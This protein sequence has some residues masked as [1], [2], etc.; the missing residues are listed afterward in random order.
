MKKPVILDLRNIYSKEIIKLG[1]KYY[2]IGNN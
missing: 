2:S 1:F